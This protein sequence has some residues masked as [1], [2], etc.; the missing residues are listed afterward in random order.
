MTLQYVDNVQ[1]CLL[2]IGFIGDD[3]GLRKTISQKK[4]ATTPR[5]GL[6]HEGLRL[7]AMAE[8]LLLINDGAPKTLKDQTTWNV[9]NRDRLEKIGIAG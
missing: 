1:K 4:I 2:L 9:G 3:A 8:I 5:S 7:G 6:I